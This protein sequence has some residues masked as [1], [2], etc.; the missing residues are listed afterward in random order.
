MTLYS[1]GIVS[2]LS[3]YNYVTAAC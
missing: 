1:V 2:K 3:F